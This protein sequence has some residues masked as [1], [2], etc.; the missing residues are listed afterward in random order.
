ML[1]EPIEVIISQHMQI[2]PHTCFVH[3][4]LKLIQEYMSIIAQYAGKYRDRHI[5]SYFKHKP[6]HIHCQK[7]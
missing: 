7:I 2:R 4:H 5:W 1:A 3:I 6:T